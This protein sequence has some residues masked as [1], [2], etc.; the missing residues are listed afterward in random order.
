M[1]RLLSRLR[2]I[3]V[4]I[5][6]FPVFIVGVSS[7]F[8]VALVYRGPRLEPLIKAV[9]RGILRSA[10]IR[11]RIR[12][13]ENVQP[14]RQYILV[15]NH[16]NFFD[17]FVFYA[18]FPGRARALEE[19]KHFR[20]P[21]Y[22]AMLRRIGMIPVDRKNRAKARESLRKAARLIRTKPDFCC[23][24]LPEGTRTRTGR[25]GPFKHGAFIL[26]AEAG[27]E[28]LPI[29]QIGAGRIN[30]KGS[31]MVRPGT[32]DVVIGEPLALDGATRES[33]DA[34]MDRTRAWFLKYVD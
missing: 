19:E 34:L 29:V 16:V 20:W 15:M 27:L 5:A 31:R 14:G 32:I 25:L 9:C 23:L 1:S 12:G 28:I 33:H 7:I 10:S 2:S 30:R 26:A 24:V 21:L 3:L 8:L 6:A 18:A 22:G 11:L 13:R 4:W 17:P